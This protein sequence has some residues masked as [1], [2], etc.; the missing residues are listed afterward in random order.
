LDKNKIKVIHNGVHPAQV[1][2]SKHDAPLNELR[3]IYVGKLKPRKGIS[4]IIEAVDTVQQKFQGIIFDII[5][6]GEQENDLRSKYKDNDKIMFHGYQKDVSVYLDKTHIGIMNSSHEG[7]PNTLLEYLS[8]GLAVITTMVDGIPEVV[9]DG[10][11]AL[12][13]NFND[14]KHI[15]NRIETLS[16]NTELRK[17]LAENGVRRIK[18]NFNAVRQAND[19]IDYL[20][21]FC[22][23]ND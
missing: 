15:V 14:L 4:A 13:I 18:E 8:H 11:T 2:L 16:N 6:D 3:I 17:N 23:F 7:L 1:N 10:V 21:A 9:E 20:T 22:T 5:G 12:S 19:V